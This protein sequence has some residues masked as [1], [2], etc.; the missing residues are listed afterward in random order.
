MPP[1]DQYDMIG[2]RLA[3][4]CRAA[5]ADPLAE[6]FKQLCECIQ[7]YAQQPGAKPCGTFPFN[8]T[9]SIQQ[10]AV[11]FTAT[12]A[13]QVPKG[14]TGVITRI[15]LQERYPGTLY[16]ANLFLIINDNMAPEFARVDT[17]IGNGSQDGVGTRICLAE[18]D[19][20][21]VMLQCSWTPVVLV[22]IESTYQQTLFTYSIE[23]Y[24]EYKEVA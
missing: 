14:M 6:G 23:G 4:A 20:V 10:T 21:S 13:F 18:Q 9:K 11:C 24:F 22:G 16:G 12:T 1:V 2:I 5:L 19:I 8:F 15:A 17:P 7:N 3:D